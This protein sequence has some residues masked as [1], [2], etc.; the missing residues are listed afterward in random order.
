MDWTT[1][2][3][4][5]TTSK[6]LETQ[7]IYN[8]ITVINLDYGINLYRNAIKKDEC[9]NIINSLENEISLGLPGIKWTGAQVNAKE[10]H[11]EVRN[12]VDLKYKRENLGKDISFSQVLFDIHESVDKSLD[13]CLG[14][15]ESL[16]HLKM[17]YKEAFNFVKYLPGKYFKIHGDHGPYYTCTVSAVVYLNDDYEGGEIQFT[18]QGLTVKP[19]AGDIILFPSNF[20]YEHASLEVFSGTKYSVVI[21]T[22]Y[23]DMYHK[24]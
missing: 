8:D 22:D 4:E 1:L 6:R 9:V 21:M 13:Y 24:E 17:H 23:N 2:P 5:E 19:E 18:R 11:N 14:H 7:T 16:W 3:R 12:C 10:D 20:V 15:Y